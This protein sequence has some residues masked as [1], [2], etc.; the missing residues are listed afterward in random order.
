MDSDTLLSIRRT[1]ASMID[2]ALHRQ[3]CI[4]ATLE[5]ACTPMPTDEEFNTMGR[6]LD[7]AMEDETIYR[8][9]L[10][11]VSRYY[12]RAQLEALTWVH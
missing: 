4:V 1:I 5:S 6:D 9:R 7:K 12:E 8:A 3:Q 11:L 10:V 2:N